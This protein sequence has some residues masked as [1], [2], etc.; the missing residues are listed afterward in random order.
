MLTLDKGTPKLARG[1]S[2]QTALVEVERWMMP[3]S[4]ICVFDPSVVLG[5]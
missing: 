4:A 5:G 3:A 2:S 1:P